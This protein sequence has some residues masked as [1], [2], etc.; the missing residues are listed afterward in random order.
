MLST[1]PGQGTDPPPATGV[2]SV[3]RALALLEVVAERGGTLGIGEIAAAA[4][5]PLPT[6]HR[7]LRTLVERGYM[8]QAPDRRY[9]L[10][11]RLVGLG[12]AAGSMAGAGAERHLR[13]LVDALGETANLAV[14]DGD[15]VAYVAQVPG[16]HAMRMFTEVG[17]RVELHCTAVGKAVLAETS[18]DAARALLSR[19][20]LS[21][22]TPHTVTEVDALVAQ[23]TEVRRR[24][25]AL[26]EEEQEVGVRCVAVAVPS[27]SPSLALS[28][29]GPAPR[30]SDA[31]VERAVPH[32]QRTARALAVEI[33]G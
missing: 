2:Q 20:R 15:H 7:L 21:R 32:L 8:R 9:A 25:Y 26:D 11:F 6:A 18:D 13:R 29:S 28:V 19:S 22:H 33:A 31:V 24:G 10:G 16:S 30:M 1:T 23:L 17:R 3:H 14:L 4:A 12:A 27:A 5:V